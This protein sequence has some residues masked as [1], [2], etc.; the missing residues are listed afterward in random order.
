MSTHGRSGNCTPGPDLVNLSTPTPGAADDICPAGHQILEADLHPLTGFTIG[1]T[2]ARRREEFG[3]ALQRRGA[4]VL[5]GPA[6]QIVPV[7]DDEA[8][9][10]VT[11]GC[12]AEPPDIVVATTGIGFRAWIEA[13]DGWGVGENLLEQMGRAWLLARGPKARGAMRAAGL[14]GEW[15]PASESSSEVLQRLLEQDLRGLRVAIQLHGEPVPDLV[16]A[17]RAAGATVVEV[18]VYRWRPPADIAPLAKLCRAVADRTLDA[19]TFTSAPAAASFLLTAQQLGIEH[20]TRDAMRQDVLV[21]A[22]GPV[23]AAPLDRLDIRVIQPDR[24]RLGSMIRK[25]LTEVPARRTRNL[26]LAGHQMQIRGQGIVIDG[27]F[28][29]LP[30]TSMALLHLLTA[31]PGQVISRTDLAGALPGSSTDEHAVEM[32]IGRLRT[33]LGDPRVVQTVL[34]RGYRIAFDPESDLPGF[35][36]HSTCSDAAHTSLTSRSG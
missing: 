23:T 24:A 11:L 14:H 4:T 19:V 33:S 35:P 18:Q 25:I 21:F 36:S 32:A 22:V 27:Q 3:A 5:Y 34:K 28:L 1:I 2:A 29:N 17:L 9:R 16:Q 30:P 10:E 6:I 15:S 20:Q 31:H 7:E 12:L 13:A 26:L 8:L